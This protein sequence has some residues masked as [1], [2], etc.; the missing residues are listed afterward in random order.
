MASITDLLGKVVGGIGK[1]AD[2]PLVQGAG[3]AAAFGA[4]PLVGLLAAGGLQRSRDTRALENEALREDIAGARESRERRGQIADLLTG[5]FG[6]GQS[7]ELPGST[8]G[9]FNET[10]PLPGRREQV[11]MI[12]TA[13]GQN[14]LQ[15]LL[16]AEQ[17]GVAA[18]AMFPQQAAPQ[19]EPTDVRTI[20]AMGL[21]PLS[22]EGNRLLRRTLEDQGIDE[23]DRRMSMMELE[24]LQSKLT[25]SA[26]KAQRERLQRQVDEAQ[27][28]DATMHSFSQLS[29]M[30]Q[31]NDVIA[32]SPLLGNPRFV[33][34]VGS[35]NIRGAL[36]LASIA[37]IDT[38]E[39]Q[40]V[41]NALVRFDQLGTA[42]AVTRLTGDAA[43]LA[44]TD[45]RFR[46]FRDTKP[47]AALGP[48]TNALVIADTIDE[49]LSFS[50]NMGYEM[51]DVQRLKSLADSIRD[52]YK[53]EFEAEESPVRTP[54]GRPPGE[55]E[56][57]Q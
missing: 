7:V 35:G 20:R 16:A 8:V 34:L 50:S 15:G 44:G 51:S 38:R 9:L 31:L 36:S 6:S 4:N 41:A 32:G 54:G 40:R 14:M 57:V 52:K 3:M 18:Q 25:E 33:E 5:D 47:N 28:K 11:P 23:I 49:M 21:D 12:N 37:G 17:P 1:I 53:S 19:T 46:T 24:M 10:I 22:G 29:E 2:N 13:Q 56:A 48:A 45:T 26:D 55:F 39:A 27:V 42:L 43:Q 30:A